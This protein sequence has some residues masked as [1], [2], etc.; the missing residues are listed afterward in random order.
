MRGYGFVCQSFLNRAYRKTVYTIDKP[1]K[2][3]KSLSLVELYV[4]THVDKFASA[5]T[6]R[7][8][9]RLHVITP[10]EGGHWLKQSE[11]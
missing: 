6:Y 7:Q 2:R 3:Q 5:S 1:L 4:N 10:D 9:H 11:K 8:N